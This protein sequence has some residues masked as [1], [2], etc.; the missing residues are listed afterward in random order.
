GGA[1]VF[2]QSEPATLTRSELA[3]DHEY[4][5]ASRSSSMSYSCPGTSGEGAPCTP[6][7]N[8]R[9]SVPRETSAD[10]PSENT[11]Q[12]LTDRDASG[13]STLTRSRA[14]G[15]PTTGSTGGATSHVSERASSN[16]W[17]PDW[18][19]GR[20]PAQSIQAAVPVS[21]RTV[22]VCE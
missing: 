5:H 8:V 16:R 9:S 21:G 1:I 14:R 3:G 15:C 13:W 12:S 4:A 11:S 17:S 2:G 6:S 18:P 22:R 10:V 19:H 20:W 7:R